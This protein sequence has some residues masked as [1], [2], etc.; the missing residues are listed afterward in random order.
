MLP[1]MWVSICH[2]EAS[3]ALDMRH[4]SSLAIVEPVAGEHTL[5]GVQNRQAVFPMGMAND[6]DDARAGGRTVTPRRP[7]TPA[8]LESAFVC[9]PQGYAAVSNP[10][11][12][13]GS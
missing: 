11:H 7:S 10:C 12:K 4:W 9:G 8:D 1:A 2:P 13:P 5:P 3:R 6:Q